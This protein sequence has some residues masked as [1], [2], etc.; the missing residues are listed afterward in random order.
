MI[1]VR[2]LAKPFQPK[3]SSVQLTNIKQTPA[4]RASI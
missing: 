2:G 1:F 3:L 4:Y